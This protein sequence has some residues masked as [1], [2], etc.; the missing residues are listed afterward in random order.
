EKRLKFLISNFYILHSTFYIQGEFPI[1][2]VEIFAQK[3]RKFRNSCSF[4]VSVE[5]MGIRVTATVNDFGSGS[6][7]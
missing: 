4:S 5:N 1:A 7:R 6:S 3:A 2:Q